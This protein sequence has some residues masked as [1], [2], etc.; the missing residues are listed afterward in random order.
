MEFQTF[1]PPIR[2]ILHKDIKFIQ[3]RKI[4]FNNS[5]NAAFFMANKK[6]LGKMCYG[7]QTNEYVGENGSEYKA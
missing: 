1:F 4:Q 7:P 2:N 6:S 5:I 3:R